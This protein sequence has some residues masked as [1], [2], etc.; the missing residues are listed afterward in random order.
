MRIAIFGA[1]G[2]TGLL[3]VEQALALGHQVTAVVRD[4]SQITARPQLDVVVADMYNQEQVTVAIKGADAVIQ[5]IGARHLKKSD[6]LPESMKRIVAGMKANGV[7]RL[8]V[9]GASGALHPA[10]KYQTFGRKIFFWIIRW[11]FLKHPMNDSGE[12]EKVVEASGLDYTVV[13]PPRLTDGPHTG[14]YRV[15]SDG[16]P[17]GGRELSRADLAEFML[18]QL[19]D[20]SSIHQGPY[21]AY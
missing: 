17:E 4:P 21:V 2:R 3:L 1:T 9:L 8:V 15:Q 18:K 10:M 19:G 5:A 11:T 13:H 14:K 20:P 6:L 12:Q 16:L 7:R